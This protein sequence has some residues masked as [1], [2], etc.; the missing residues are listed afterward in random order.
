MTATKEAIR[1]IL[2]TPDESLVIDVLSEDQVD[3]IISRRHEISN[4]AGVGF[5]T[6]LTGACCCAEVDASCSDGLTEPESTCL[7]PIPT[8]T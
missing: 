5:T 2:G 7:T 3:E 6:S 1:K 4:C 8:C